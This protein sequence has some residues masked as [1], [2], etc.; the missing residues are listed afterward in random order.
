MSDAECRVYASIVRSPWQYAVPSRDSRGS[1]DARVRRPTPSRSWEEE[2][3]LHAVSF[4]GRARMSVSFQS[5]SVIV[6]RRSARA[7]GPGEAVHAKRPVPADSGN[8]PFASME[9]AT[10]SMTA[11]ERKRGD[12]SCFLLHGHPRTPAKRSEERRVG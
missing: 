10:T 7:G 12:I 1:R 5:A 6:W 2:H 8:S 9:T 3:R 4:P 11:R